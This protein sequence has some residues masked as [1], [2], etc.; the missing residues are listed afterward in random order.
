MKAIFLRC[1]IP[2]LDLDG[3]I[4]SVVL[5]AGSVSPVKLDS[6][7]FKSTAWKEKQKTFP[8]TNEQLVN[9]SMEQ[10]IV[11]KLINN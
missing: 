1:E 4:M 10:Q 6:S 5:L 8:L 11:Y 9:I 2:P 7:I 3:G